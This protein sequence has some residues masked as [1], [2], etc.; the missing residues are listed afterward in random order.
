[1]NGEVCTGLFHVAER[2]KRATNHAR[3][4]PDVLVGR[5]SSLTPLL[6]GAVGLLARPT[7]YDP[8]AFPQLAK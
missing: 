8:V 4:Q 5:A 2:H 6:V 7:I 3:R 1:M